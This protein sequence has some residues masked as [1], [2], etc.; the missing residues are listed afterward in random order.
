MT[1]NRRRY[2]D[3]KEKIAR[4]R[5]MC[6]NL[7]M[8]FHGVKCDRCGN[9]YDYRYAPILVDELF[10]ECAGELGMKAFLCADCMEKQIGGKI[11]VTQL[12]PCQISLNYLFCNDLDVD[13]DGGL[14][15]LEA[16]HSCVDKLISKWENVDES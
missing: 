6:V 12:K 10:I 8:S 15:A 3:L 5:Y 1:K 7:P 13:C 16:M 4:S 14:E 9:K 2:I 11:K